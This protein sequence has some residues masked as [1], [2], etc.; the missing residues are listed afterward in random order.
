[1]ELQFRMHQRPE[2]MDMSADIKNL[3]IVSCKYNN[4]ATGSQVR[5]VNVHFLTS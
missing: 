3:G 5:T 4:R 1:M 2:T